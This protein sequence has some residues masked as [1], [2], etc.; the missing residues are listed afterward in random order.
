MIVKSFPGALVAAGLVL[1]GCADD[2][3]AP[4][5]CPNVV[6][7][8][9]TAEVTKFLPGPGRDLTDVVLEVKIERFDGFCDTELDDGEAVSVTVEMQLF[10]TAM[11]GPAS[12]DRRGT[13]TYFVAIADQWETILAK[14]TFASEFVFEGNRSRTTVFEDLTEEIPLQTG[15]LGD[16][17]NIY[18]GFQLTPDELKYNQRKLGR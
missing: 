4:P 16:V 3:G 1:A 18:I 8:Q 11:R 14:E 9:D 17:Y 6:V 5:P 13:V 15:E 10:L 12:R 7:V 2:I